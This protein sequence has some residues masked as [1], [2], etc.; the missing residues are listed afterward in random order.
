MC[1]CVYVY[2]CMCGVLRALCVAAYVCCGSGTWRRGGQKGAS[3]H[4]RLLHPRA[5]LSC[6]DACPSVP[7][8]CCLPC[9]SCAVCVQLGP[10]DSGKSTL[11]RLLCNWAVRGGAKPMFVDLDVG[12]AHVLSGP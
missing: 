2:V 10:T 8:A 6:A 4:M 3:V 12:K 5:A 9:S 11:C 7:P 1:V